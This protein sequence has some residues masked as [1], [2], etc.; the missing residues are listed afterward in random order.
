L[1]NRI[2][3]PSSAISFNRQL[4]ESSFTSKEVYRIADAV[5]FGI[6]SSKYQGLV[7]K[8]KSITTNSSTGLTTYVLSADWTDT[9]IA[10]GYPFEMSVDIPTIYRATVATDSTKTDT[11]SY[12]TVHRCKFQYG[13]IGTFNTTVTHLG[14]SDYK[15]TWE[16]S[17]S[18]NYILDTHEVLPTAFHTLPIYDKNTNANINLYSKHPTPTVLL[19]ME[20][21]GKLST[22]QYTSV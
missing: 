6:G 20:W 19:S 10:I 3:I 12:L 5:A 9:S 11:R 15:A 1:D 2:V 4:F 14:K 22:K 21:E 16:M 13:D 18:D 8:F 17:P 7:A